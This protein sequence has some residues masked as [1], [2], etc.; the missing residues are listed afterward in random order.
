[1]AKGGKRGELRRRL[2]RW[3][4]SAPAVPL[5]FAV[6]GGQILA[7]ILHGWGVAAG[8]AALGVLCFICRG[9][10]G[11]LISGA[12]IG[13]VAAQVTSVR[14]PAMPAVDD[15]TLMGIVDETPRR[16]RVGEVLFSLKTELGGDSALIRCRAVDL[17]W[18][19]AALLEAGS[20]VAVR[21]RFTPVERS[22]NPFS[23]SGW[24]WRKGFS[25]ECRA[26]FV[27][28]PSASTTSF[29]VSLRDYIK[30]SVQRAVGDSVGSGLFL[31]MSLGYHDLLSVQ[32]ERAFMALGLTHLLVV[33]GYQVSL[34]FGCMMVVASSIMH[35][36]FC[37]SRYARL[38][39]GGA[40]LL[41]ASVYVYCIGLEMSAVRAWVA[42]ACV[43]AQFLSDRR[44]SF[45][46]RWGVALLLMQ[47][48]WP[49]CIFDI[50]VILTFAALAGIGIGAQ[51]GGGSRIGTM[52]AVNCVVW[53]AT[54]LVVVVWRGTF[55]PFGLLL[56]LLIAAP[57]SV[58]NCAYGLL[59][60][61][62]LVSGVPGA[63]TLLELLTGLNGLLAAV[64]LDLGEGRFRGWELEW[65]ARLATTAVMLA[66]TVFVARRA[67]RK[68]EPFGVRINLN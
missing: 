18:R 49:W 33:S 25:G 1:V 64:V 34:M 59:A 2:S 62:L 3:R 17:P 40:A 45:W 57:W 53:L 28:R 11:V 22:R 21:G 35:F 42:A 52:I 31:S 5:A 39:V 36:F 61:L 56:N 55:S 8:L 54:S 10:A 47:L 27:S 68:V 48:A 38:L 13:L 15:A 65:P 51:L 20:L 66:T 4:R 26:H 58:A 19:N 46:Q 67:C 63:Q 50:G 6:A 44:T 60:L 29:A 12:I 23:W 32:H 16:P 30:N 14:P 24:L 43:S 37:G 9:R 41:A 7:W